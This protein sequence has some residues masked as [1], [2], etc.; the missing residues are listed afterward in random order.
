[1][2]E[3]LLDVIKFIHFLI[4]SFNCTYIFLFNPIYD[5]YFAG[6]ILTQT[7]HWAALKNECVFSYI[8]KK[9]MN[10]DYELG[11]DPKHMPHNEVY[12]NDY[13]LTIKALLIVS[14]LL[15]IAYRS[16]NRYAKVFAIFASV[17]WI[18]LTYFHNDLQQEK[19]K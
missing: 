16:K 11:S 10:P 17:L 2:T 3:L 15:I 9:L 6:W 18:Y 8:E 7:L 1:M 14:T 12:H 4:D 5:V 13:T 19:L